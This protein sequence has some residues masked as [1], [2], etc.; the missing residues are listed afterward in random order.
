MRLMNGATVLQNASIADAFLAWSIAGTG[1]FN[2][3]GKSDLL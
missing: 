2:G 3:D 1:D